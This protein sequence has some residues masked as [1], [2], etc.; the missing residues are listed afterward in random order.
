VADGRNLRAGP[1][2]E[3]ASVA[4]LLRNDWCLGN[5]LERDGKV[6]VEEWKGG[7]MD[8]FERGGVCTLEPFASLRAGSG[9]V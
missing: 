8:A 7:R 3:I 6:R 1:K 4:P 2:R 5:R 9:N